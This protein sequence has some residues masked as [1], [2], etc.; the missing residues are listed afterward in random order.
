MWAAAIAA[1][2]TL[3]RVEALAMDLITR[4]DSSLDVIMVPVSAEPPAYEARL[5]R[6]E[7]AADQEQSRHKAE[8]QHVA[9]ENEQLKEQ[10]KFLKAAL[11][12]T[13]S[14]RATMQQAMQEMSME[15]V[16]AKQQRAELQEE[17]RQL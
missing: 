12:D 14:M 3:A 10:I 1:G 17:L 6:L 4:P 8:Q 16:N 9:D 13:V 7:A 11:E 15:L 2:T 5:H